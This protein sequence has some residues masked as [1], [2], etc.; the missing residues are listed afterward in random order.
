MAETRGP[1]S[2]EHKIAVLRRRPLQYVAV[3]DL[4][5]D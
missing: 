5:D 3:W 1:F 4:C 2:A